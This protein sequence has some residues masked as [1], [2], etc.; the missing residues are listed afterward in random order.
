MDSKLRSEESERNGLPRRHARHHVLSSIQ[1]QIVFLYRISH[2]LRPR[3]RQDFLQATT[4]DEQDIR[5][6]ITL[7]PAFI[8]FSFLLHLSSRALG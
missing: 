6:P 2:L 4:Q 8:H 3:A 5:V 7:P 1:F